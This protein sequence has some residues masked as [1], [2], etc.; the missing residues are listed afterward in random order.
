MAVVVLTLDQRRSRR[1]PDLV[2]DLLGRLAEAPVRRAFART[3]GDEVQGVLDDPAAVVAA[4][5]LL[6]RDGGW[7]VGVGVGDVEQPLPTD[8]RAGRGS[9]FLRARTAVGRAKSSPAHLAVVGPEGRAAEHLEG[10]S[11]LWAAVLGRRSARG[12]EVADL[13]DAGATYDEA[14]ARLGISPSAVSQRARAAGLAESGR[15]RLIAE[16]LLRQLL[17]PGADEGGDEDVA[18]G[19]GVV[20]GAVSGVGSDVGGSDR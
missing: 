6:L 5:E 14:A 4:L 20:S 16:D 10:V 19:S 13:V 8:V 18:A 1:G 17:R 9:A 15:A 11:W 2:P 3:A 12:W 7:H